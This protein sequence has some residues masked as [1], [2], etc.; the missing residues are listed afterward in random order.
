MCFPHAT[1]TCGHELQN[2][3]VNAQVFFA[4]TT[5]AGE[6]MSFMYIYI[7][8]FMYVC[9]YVCMYTAKAKGASRSEF[10]KPKLRLVD[11]VA[12]APIPAWRRASRSVSL[13]FLL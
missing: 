1:S 7:D 8:V 13:I 12:Q 6:R 5:S 4:C 11:Q 2:L 3:T 9:M 10:Q